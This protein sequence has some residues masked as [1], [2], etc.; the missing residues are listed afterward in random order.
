MSSCTLPAR[1]LER[2]R[3]ARRDPV[4][5]Q[6]DYLILRY[7]VNHLERVLGEIA[8]PVDDVLDLWCGTQPYRDLLPPHT[9]HVSMDIDDRYGTP[10]VISEEFLPFPNNSFDLI[11]FTEAFYYLTDPGAGAAELARVLRPGG[12]LVLTVPLVWE[13]DRRIVEHR[14]TGPGL[15]EVFEKWD[16]VRIWENGGYSV[17]WATLTGRILRGIDELLPPPARR[18]LRPVF[19]AVTVAMNGVATLLANGEA[20][21][22]TSPFVLPMGLLLTA[23]SPGG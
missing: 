3:R 2:I 10:D 17:A 18:L 7:L 12:T 1:E 8:H 16:E 20:R 15:A 14:Y 5:S 23:R 19:A 6:P 4:R 13:Y 11:L 22:H 9:R 21:W